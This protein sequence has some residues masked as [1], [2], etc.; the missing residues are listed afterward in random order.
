MIDEGFSEWAGEPLESLAFIAERQR[1]R[2]SGPAVAADALGIVA[3]ADRRGRLARADRTAPAVVDLIRGGFCDE[4]GGLTPLGERV[5]SHWGA[6]APVLEIA[7]RGSTPGTLTA[8]AGPGSVLVAASSPVGEPPLSA[9]ML[10]LGMVSIDGA[11]PAI[12]SW[13]GLRPVWSFADGP[14][15]VA[16]ETYERRVTD[17]STPVPFDLAPHLERLWSAEWTEYACRSA[18]RTL[19]FVLTPEGLFSVTIAGSSARLVTV[20]PRAVFTAMLGQYS[21][22]LELAR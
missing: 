11:L 19:R 5:R 13:I 1:F 21:D 20:T 22:A 14:V 3:R 9:G 12:C 4:R 7:R 18:Q 6:T 15:D 8:W 10:Q 16:A 17:A 2:A